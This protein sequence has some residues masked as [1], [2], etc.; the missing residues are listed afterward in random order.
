MK[1]VNFLYITSPECFI[2]QALGA[3]ARLVRKEE[4]IHAYIQ[5]NIFHG[6]SFIQNKI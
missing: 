5:L 1:S 6:N 3:F 2:V 4:A